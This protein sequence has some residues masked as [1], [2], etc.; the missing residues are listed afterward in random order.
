MRDGRRNLAV[1]VR[2]E[3]VP[4]LWHLKESISGLERGGEHARGSEYGGVCEGRGRMEAL[5]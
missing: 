1:E 3:N 4:G 2:P 5:P